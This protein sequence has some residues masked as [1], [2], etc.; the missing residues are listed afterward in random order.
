MTTVL[1]HSVGGSWGDNNSCCP[2]NGDSTPRIVAPVVIQRLG[3]VRFGTSGFTRH[4]GR[5][6]KTNKQERKK[7]IE[8]SAEGEVTV[9]AV[10]VV[11]GV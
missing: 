1:H 6:R 7:E 9:G 3:M 8:T 10:V 2:R 4:G 5:Q 11:I